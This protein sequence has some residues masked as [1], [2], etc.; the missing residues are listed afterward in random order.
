VA[1]VYGDSMAIW[2][3]KAEAG[4]PIDVRVRG[5]GQ[6]FSTELVLGRVAEE[7]LEGLETGRPLVAAWS[8]A[9]KKSRRFRRSLFPG[10]II[11]ALQSIRVET[12]GSALRNN[13]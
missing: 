8:I 6:E 11:S 7:G 9:D 10:I 13:F 3:C 5:S 4:V 1:A 2:Y 12:C